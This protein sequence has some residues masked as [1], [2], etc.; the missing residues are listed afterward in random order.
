M[1]NLLCLTNRNIQGFLWDSNPPPPAHHLPTAAVF[2]QRDLLMLILNWFYEN[3]PIFHNYN[4]IISVGTNIINLNITSY[5]QKASNIRNGWL[6]R[7]M[8]RGCESLS[9]PIN[10]S[11]T[12]HTVQQYRVWPLVTRVRYTSKVIVKVNLK[13]FLSVNN[14]VYMK[15]EPNISSIH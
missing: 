7:V 3:I 8:K 13:R 15:V 10:A 5:Q 2:P 4:E 11:L 6:Q 14:V 1:I 9:L 12:S